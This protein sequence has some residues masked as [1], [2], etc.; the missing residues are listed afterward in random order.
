MSLR[1]PKFIG[2][3]GGIGA[4][5]TELLNYIGKH[6]KCEIYLADRV[7]H[8]VKEP[9]TDCYRAL[10]ALLGKDITGPEGQIDKNRMAEK[11]F[12]D[13]KLLEQVN[14]IIHPAVKS[15]L[16]ERLE[17]A[18]RKSETELFFVEAALLIECGYGA[19][20][21]EMWYI[22]A[23]RETRQKRLRQSRGYS[24]ERIDGIMASQLS[25]EQFRESCDFVIDNSK[26]LTE[27]FAQIDRKLEAF[28][29]QE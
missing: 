21:D 20:V 4:G 7:A 19:L 27:S 16:L 17:R 11:I 12:S 8:E 15:Y 22:Y 29:W 14:G 2:I 3:T 24:G 23:D 13:G 5:K 18:R 10:V 9:G 25:E 6:Y 26:T 28:T 1:R